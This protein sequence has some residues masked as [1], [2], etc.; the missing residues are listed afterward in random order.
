MRAAVHSSLCETTAEPIS[1]LLERV[2]EAAQAVSDGRLNFSELHESIMQLED[3]ILRLDASGENAGTLMDGLTSQTITGIRNAYNFWQTRIDSEFADSFVRGEVSLSDHILYDR[4]LDLVCR[5]RELLSIGHSDRVL[6]VGSGPLPI[7]A[8]LFHQQTGCQVD[9][10]AQN[11]DTMPLSQKILEKSGNG[12][13]VRVFDGT[14]AEYNLSNYNAVIVDVLSRP[15][16]AILKALRKRCRPSCE[17]LCRTSFGL[18]QLFYKALSD[19]DLRGFHVKK[20][21]MAKG[22]QILSIYLLE[23]AKSAAASVKLEWLREVDTRTASQLLQLMNRT[24]REETTIGFPGPID[25]A[26]GH[27]LMLQLGEDVA[28]GKRHVLVAEK[29][30]RIVGQLILTPNSSP[31]HRHIVELT[32]GTIDHSFRGGGLSLRAFQEVAKKCDEL[33]REVICLDVRA[34]TLAA[35]WWHHF[36]FKPYGLL[37]DYSRVGNKRYQGL[38]LT[39]TT[40]ELKQRLNELAVAPDSGTAA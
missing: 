40:A 21:F 15:R 19:Q 33:G 11:P 38:Y 31:N 25:E 2:S 34:G 16:K 32:R 17:I 26:S 30:D 10:L 13:S 6:M 4:F 18:R 24:L 23:P 20:Q 35:M 9:C 27:S 3:L 12:G 37:N 1:S 39:Q 36:G 14:E 28:A 7:S 8:I 22:R 29:D 5:G